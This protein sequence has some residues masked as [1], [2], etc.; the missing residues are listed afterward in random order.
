M[1][2]T[3]KPSENVKPY[4]IA[5]KGKKEEVELMF[6]SIS[7]R[8]DLL[9]H[10]LSMGIDK[11]W[12][13]KA[14]DL[15]RNMH[16]ATILDVATGTADFAIAAL[17]T[18]AGQ[19]TGIDISNGMLEVGRQKIKAQK[20][21]DTICLIQG[22]SEALPFGDNSFDA[23]TAAFGVRNFENLKKGLTEMYR[24]LRPGG[25][26]VILEFSRP[27]YFPVR[28]LYWF[29]FRSILPAVGRIISKDRS[30]YSYLP[31]SVNAFPD[32]K[33]FLKILNASGF[34]NESQKQLTFG[35]ASIYSGQKSRPN[36]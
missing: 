15:L 1:N 32:G 2:S 7:G 35:I 6:D 18:G 36:A 33:D 29:Y 13:R 16:P 24:V 25:K 26:V 27:K 20:L 28:Q 30:A 3:L 11:G 22:D 17:S 14:I 10:L 23:V 12:R 8:Y 34:V 21:E 5:T 31:E 19:I 9:N 4:G